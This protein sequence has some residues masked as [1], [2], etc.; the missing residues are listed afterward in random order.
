M[1][2]SRSADRHRFQA[3]DLERTRRN[4]PLKSPD[5]HLIQ[6][7]IDFGELPGT[8]TPDVRAP[9]AKGLL[10]E[11]DVS[12]RE[13]REKMPAK[14]VIPGGT[15]RGQ[16]A[17]FGPKRQGHD[18]QNLCRVAKVLEGVHRDNHIRTF[19][20]G[21]RKGNVAA[22]RFRS[23]LSRDLQPTLL[24][25]NPVDVSSASLSQ[26]NRFRALSTPEVNHVFPADLIPNA[27]P[28]QSD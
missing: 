16:N 28:E 8:V 10:T 22:V 24:D 18:S 15:E 2:D 7:A 13:Y 14:R 6:S 20:R 26:F 4:E 19:R 11:N 17:S 25:V 9:S 3:L 1:K 21:T 23:L 5:R 27:V 12:P